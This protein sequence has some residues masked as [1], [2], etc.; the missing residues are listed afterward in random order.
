VPSNGNAAPSAQT[1]PATITDD[2]N[3]GDFTSSYPKPPHP[4]R[5]VMRGSMMSGPVTI[6]MVNDRPERRRVEKR[7][8]LAQEFQEPGH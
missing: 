3:D 6:E 5:R 2:D 4:R 7:S 1:D 8:Q